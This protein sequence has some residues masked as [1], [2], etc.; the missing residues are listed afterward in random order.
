[1][2]PC[3]PASVHIC[4]WMSRHY[5][6]VLTCTT[7][8]FVERYIN[9]TSSLLLKDTGPLPRKQYTYRL[10]QILLYA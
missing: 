5:T 8:S 3:E 1:M 4:I 10:L 7:T 6:T 2:R 9:K